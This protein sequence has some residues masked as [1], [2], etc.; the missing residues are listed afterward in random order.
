[1]VAERKQC[2]LIPN[3][4]Y[5]PDPVKITMLRCACLIGNNGHNTYFVPTGIA[6]VEMYAKGPTTLLRCAQVRRIVPLINTTF[7]YTDFIEF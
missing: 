6:E 4:I 5:Q 1:M 3:S 2:G 7:E